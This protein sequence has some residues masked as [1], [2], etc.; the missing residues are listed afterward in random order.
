MY[1]VT[2]PPPVKVTVDGLKY[3]DEPEGRFGMLSVTDEVELADGVRVTVV[4]G[5]D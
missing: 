1:E 5:T 4:C 2:D 3:A